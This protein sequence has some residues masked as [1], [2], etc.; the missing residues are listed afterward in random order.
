MSQYQILPCPNCN[1][2]GCP[3]C[4]N[5]GRVKVSQEQFQKLKQMTG[6]LAQRPA[7][8][9]P[10]PQ[11]SSQVPWQKVRS[12]ANLSGIIAFSILSIIA[13]AAAASWYFLKTLKPFFSGFIALLTVIGTT[14]AWHRPFFQPRYPNDF[15]SAIKLKPQS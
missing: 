13:G 4:K 10:P 9:S 8:F 1:G 2:R 11:P 3:I 15:L 7:P 5:T 12:N 14:L 6:Q